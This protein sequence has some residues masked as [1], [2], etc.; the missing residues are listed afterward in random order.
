MA[1]SKPLGF[2]LF[3]NLCRIHSS[4]RW[5]QLLLRLPGGNH[6]LDG[7]AVCCFFSFGTYKSRYV[8]L[9]LPL[10]EQSVRVASDPD[11]MATAKLEAEKSSPAGVFSHKHSVPDFLK[12]LPRT[13]STAK[14]KGR[15]QN[16]A[17]SA[18]HG[19][20]KETLHISVPMIIKVAK[21]QEK[22]RG[23]KDSS[24]MGCK[25][26]SSTLPQLHIVTSQALFVKC[27]FLTWKCVASFLS[28]AGRM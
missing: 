26:Y 6:V 2:K 25:I 24:H 8:S 13:L 3:P 18:P 5:A 11:E 17:T 22:S 15:W 10:L 20:H 16:S 23:M 19:F 14:Q 12:H 1:D 7:N 21:V 4:C 27:C 9:K 28:K